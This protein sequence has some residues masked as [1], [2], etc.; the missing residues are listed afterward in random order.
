MLP[1][2]LV[3]HFLLPSFSLAF[4]IPASSPLPIHASKRH[5]ATDAYKTQ[6]KT[7]TDIDI[8]SYTSYLCTYRTRSYV[9]APSV[10][11]SLPSSFPFSLSPSLPPSLPS[12]L[13]TFL[14]RKYFY[15]F[16]L[17]RLTR[18]PSSRGRMTVPPWPSFSSLTASI[19]AS[20]VPLLFPRSTPPSHG[21]PSGSSGGPPKYVCQLS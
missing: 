1:L 6:A 19:P 2:S 4:S 7:Q 12:S 17:L 18:K 11:L 15:E 13:L 16:W 9:I 3:Q 5:A 10:P 14:A 8:H 20:S 21:N